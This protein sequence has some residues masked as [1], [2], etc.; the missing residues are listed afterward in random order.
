MFEPGEVVY[1]FVKTTHPPKNKYF[2]T[3]Y[4]DDE[5][6]IVTCFTTTQDRVGTPL[7]I[8]RHGYVRKE[9]QIVGYCFDCTVEVGLDL[10]NQPYKFPRKCVIPFDYG[11]NQGTKDQFLKI[12]ENPVVVCR[13][14]PKEYENLVYAMYRSPRTNPKYLPYLDKVLQEICK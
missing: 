3:I 5:L 12:V 6:R 2:V 9:G 14:H 7:E 13:L 8:L 1:A 10:S 11:V 4:R